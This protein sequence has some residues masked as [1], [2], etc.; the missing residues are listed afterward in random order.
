MM[1]VSL[2][3]QMKKELT[4]R[5]VFCVSSDLDESLRERAW[6]ERKPVSQ[7]VRELCERGLVEL[8][9]A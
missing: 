9:S 1:G 7:L 6:E 5:I 2:T 8:K 3:E 4:K